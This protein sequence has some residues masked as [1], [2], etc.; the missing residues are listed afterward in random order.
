VDFLEGFARIPEVF[1]DVP[2]DHDIEKR[3]WIVRIGKDL[4]YA[5]IG[6]WIY[7]RG[8]GFA[9]IGAVYLEAEIGHS[10]KHDASST[11]NVQHASRF[12]EPLGDESRLPVAYDP[13]ESFYGRA[14]FVTRSS[15][16]VVRV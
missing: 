6:P 1:K 11:P 14:K 8:C 10:R 12:R 4:G 15:I 16:V 13:Y 2:N 7:S 9:D 3:I 5:N